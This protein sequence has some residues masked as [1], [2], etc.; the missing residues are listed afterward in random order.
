MRIL[1]FW[2]LPWLLLA[3]EI[4]LEFLKE[5]PEG[6]TRDFYIWQFLDQN[7]T[8]GEANEAYKLVYRSNTKLFGRYFKKS[9]NKTLSRRTICERMSLSE[10]LKQ[11][12]KCI[13]YALKLSDAAKM[14]KSDLQKL[15]KKLAID[16]P[17]TAKH[18]EILA[19]KEPLKNLLETNATTFATLFEG[20]G[21]EYRLEQFNRFIPANAWEN[22][23][24]QND[25]KMGRMIQLIILNS[26]YVALQDSLSKVTGITNTDDRTLFY[27]GLNALVHGQKENAL[28]YFLRAQTKAKDPLLITRALFWRYLTTGD[29]AILE[30]VAQSRHPNIY[31]IYA[32][33]TLQKEPAFEIVRQ[34]LPKD[35]PPSAPWDTKDPFAW[36]KIEEQ[37]KKS[38]SNLSALPDS[39]L[40]YRNTE[41]HL[42]LIMQREWRFQKHFFITPYQEIFSQ[43]DSDKQALL[44]ALARQESH[45]IP[46]VISTSYALGMMQIMPF[47]VESIAKNL[48]E[49]RELTDMFDPALNV[50]YAEIFLR[51]L[52]REFSHPLFISYA[53]NGGPGF[54]RRLLA[55][56][57]LFRKDRALDPWYSLEMIPYEES[58]YYGSRVLA[59]YIIYQQAF[60]KNLQI[61][62]LLNETL[63]R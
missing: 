31:S 10:L 21:Q 62:D 15:S 13:G 27:L 40:R 47:N 9:D 34:V 5:K 20:V 6:I 26:A 53:Y 23:A 35:A 24:N 16:A 12:P 37:S 55:R 43:F 63:I 28:L 58:R 32:S 46:T 39:P 8:S 45:L 49:R 60:G 7:I 42:A 44:Y 1:L 61:A 22:L 50:K 19:S 41:S 14:S 17:T 38:D 4:T 3:Q 36:L 57:E 2:L 54:T 11:E 48:G 56:G 51:D 52:I 33:Q 18:L 25:Y 59:N 30:E 29:K